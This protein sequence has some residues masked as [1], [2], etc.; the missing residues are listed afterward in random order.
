MLDQFDPKCVHQPADAV[1]LSEGGSAYQLVWGRRHTP[2]LLDKLGKIY[3][4]DFFLMGHQPQ[5]FGYTVQ[6][7]RLIILASDH[8]HGVFLP[9]DCRKSYDIE[10]L[11]ERIYPLAGVV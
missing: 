10:G 7:D 4:V 6:F 5:E 3:E 2:E 8:N 1:D 11:I 9:I